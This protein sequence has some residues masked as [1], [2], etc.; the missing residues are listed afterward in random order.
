MSVAAR[1]LRSVLWP[2]VMVASIVAVVVLVETGLPVHVAAFTI[3]V[4]NLVLVAGL[5][6]V[7]P[8]VEGVDLFTDPQAPRDAAHGVLT[9]LVGAPLGTVVVTAALAAVFGDSHGVLASWWPRGWAL[10]AQVLTAWLVYGFGDYWK[11]RAYHGVD[12][13]W[14]LHAVHHDVAQMHVLKGSR[15]HLL[16]GTIRAALVS[17]PLLLLGVP[18]EV[19]VWAT[20]FDSFLGNLNHS[21]LDQRFPRVAHWLVPTI[22]LHHIH[23]AVERELHD[24]NLGIPIFDLAF[25]TYTSPDEVPRP[26]VGIAGSPVPGA[27]GGQLLFP[28]RQWRRSVSG[29]RAVSRVNG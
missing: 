28:F 8:R 26:A 4:G 16:E 11:H 23:H 21:N 2:V 10:G 29:A 20:T 22:D 14:W 17:L 19:L 24:T 27:L 12:A 15:L 13:L 7:W 1:M 9:S 5:E 6:R 18:G 3:V 25:G